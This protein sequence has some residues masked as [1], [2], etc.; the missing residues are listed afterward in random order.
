MIP[1][2]RMMAEVESVFWVRFQLWFMALLTFLF[3][4]GLDTAGEAEVAD[5]QLAV[6]VDQQVGG[7]WY[8][9]KKG[10]NIC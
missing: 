2:I 7:L 4:F 8:R 10:A 6:A 3:W 9:R 5:A 1:I